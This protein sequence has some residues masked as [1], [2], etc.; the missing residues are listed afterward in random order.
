MTATKLHTSGNW[1][2]F[3]EDEANERTNAN[4]I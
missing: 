2:R 4:V 1:R 3:A